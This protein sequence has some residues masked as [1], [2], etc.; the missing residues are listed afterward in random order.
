MFFLLIWVKK[1][2]V[3]HKN[4]L[5]FLRKNGISSELFPDCIKLKKQMSYSNKKN[6]KYTAII[7]EDELKTGKI[8]LRNM[9]TGN[10]ELLT[11]DELIKKLKMINIL[12]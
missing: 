5:I 9:S 7:G 2:R 8:N 11:I 3:F 1:K 4:L 10:Q 6:S 12:K